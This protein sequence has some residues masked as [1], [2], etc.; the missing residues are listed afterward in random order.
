MKKISARKFPDIVRHGAHALN[1]SNDV[2]ERA[3][4]PRR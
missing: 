4:I 3:C 2:A 1:R